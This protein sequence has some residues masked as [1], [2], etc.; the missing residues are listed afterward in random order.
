MCTIK[1]MKQS[2]KSIG[3]RLD[4]RLYDALMMKGQTMM[5]YEGRYISESEL[6]HMAIASFT[7]IDIKSLGIAF[8]SPRKEPLG[9]TAQEYATVSADAR[10]ARFDEA[11][12]MAVQFRNTKYFSIQPEAVQET[13][14]TASALATSGIIPKPEGF[15][16]FYNKYIKG[17]DN[18]EE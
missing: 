11:L 7:K 4:R 5:E 9:P 13:I 3:C 18:E 12:D 2:R 15:D 8:R 10:I 1:T 16:E 6:L 14:R 17:E